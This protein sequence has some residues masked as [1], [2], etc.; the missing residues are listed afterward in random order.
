[1]IP[2]LPTQIQNRMDRGARWRGDVSFP[3]ATA[4]RKQSRCMGDP[5]VHPETWRGIPPPGWHSWAHAD[6]PSGPAPAPHTSPPGPPPELTQQLGLSPDAGRGQAGT[7]GLP[8]EPSRSLTLA[9][10]AMSLPV[11]SEMTTLLWE[12][13]SCLGLQAFYK[14]SGHV[15]VTFFLPRA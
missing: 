2:L 7:G 12:L 11:V 6:P 10:G 5:H 14:F 13:P 4:L 9:S 3:N 1:M 15:A 8:V